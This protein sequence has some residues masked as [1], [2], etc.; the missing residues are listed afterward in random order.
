MDGEHYVWEV[1]Y[2]DGTAEYSEL[3]DGTPYTETI[4]TDYGESD[5]FMEAYNDYN[6]AMTV[7]GRA[8]VSNTMNAFRKSGNQILCTVT[9]G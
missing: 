7:P 8:I 9:G 5:S 3:P 6:A 1:K 4:H 2:T